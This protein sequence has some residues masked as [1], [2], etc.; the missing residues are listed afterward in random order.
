VEE[1]YSALNSNGVALMHDAFGFVP[2]LMFANS[3]ALGDEMCL[4]G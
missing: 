4:D 3:S 2:P 1:K